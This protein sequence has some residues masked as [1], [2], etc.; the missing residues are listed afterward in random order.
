M[1]AQTATLMNV[2]LTA[3]TSCNVTVAQKA[4]SQSQVITYDPNS[5]TEL[6]LTATISGTANT[7][8]FRYAAGSIL[9]QS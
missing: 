2:Y 3:V 6:G 7:L 8:T 5:I 1:V 4:R 9:Y